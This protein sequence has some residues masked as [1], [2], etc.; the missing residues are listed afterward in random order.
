MVNDDDFDVEINS[1]IKL[2]S[3]IATKK[4]LIKFNNVVSRIY[5]DGNS[6]EV[7]PAAD[8]SDYGADYTLYTLMGNYVQSEKSFATVNSYLWDVV[9]GKPGDE[10]DEDHVTRFVK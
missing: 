4:A 10:F 2:M 7:A 3:L 5:F 9:S 8:D 6:T 1:A